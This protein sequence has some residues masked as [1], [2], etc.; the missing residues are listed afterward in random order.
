MKKLIHSLRAYIVLSLLLGLVYPLFITG[1]AQLAMPQ[2]A[3]GSL[4]F[5]GGKIIGSCLIGQAFTKPE[6]FHGRP[7]ANNYDG[8][9]SGGTNFGPSSKKLMDSVAERIKQARQDNALAQETLIPA[10]MVLSSASGL[11]PHISPENAAIQAKRVAN[12]RGI[13]EDQI[14]DL[15]SDN[16]DDDFIGLWG[17]PGVNVVTLNDALDRISKKSLGENK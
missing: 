5:E 13:P 14:N 8:T 11:D 16:T 4:I 15:I 6:Y 9:N 10:D 3:C 1:L 17:R 7:S 2:R 12:L